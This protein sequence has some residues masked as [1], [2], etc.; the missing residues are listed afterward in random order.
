MK[1][2]IL[3]ATISAIVIL[4]IGIFMFAPKAND[5]S[6]KNLAPAKDQPSS[7]QAAT[8]A[9][10]EA[11]APGAYLDYSEQAF[12]DAQGT[13]ILFFHAAWCPQCKALDASIKAGVVPANTTILKVDYDSSQDLRRKYGVTTQTTLV[14]VDSNGDLVNRYIAYSTPSLDALI[15]NLL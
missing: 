12:A 4:V 2:Y 11:P 6:S 5:Y 3:P 8:N 1:K 7:Q 15:S 9:D 10:A 14:L 13:R